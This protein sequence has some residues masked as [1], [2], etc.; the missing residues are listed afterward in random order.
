VVVVVVVVV[1]AVDVV[2]Q[3]STV[4]YHQQPQTPFVLLLLHFIITTPFTIFPLFQR[5][6]EEV[7]GVTGTSAVEAT[8]T[9]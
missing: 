3:L 2:H 8:T 9:E 1:V 7:R 6:K 4:S 5:D